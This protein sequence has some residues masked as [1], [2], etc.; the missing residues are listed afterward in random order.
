MEHNPRQQN[1]RRGGY[2]H[3]SAAPAEQMP[4]NSFP[5]H[6]YAP[7]A[8][9]AARPAAKPKNQARNTHG[10]SF[11]AV[12]GSIVAAVLLIL[13][14]LAQ[15]SYIEVTREAAALNSELRVLSEQRRRLEIH[16]E[17]VI[18]MQAVERFA[19]DVLGMTQPGGAAAT[20]VL[21]TTQDRAVIIEN[22]QN[23][24]RLADFGRFLSSLFDRFR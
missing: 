14:I 5:E 6:I 12:M 18:N 9:P 11:V 23:E 4:G 21:A 17:S 24:D 15:I 16:Y 22:E 7:D 3:G 8:Q 20:V 13:V 19:R 2:V 1:Y 10:V